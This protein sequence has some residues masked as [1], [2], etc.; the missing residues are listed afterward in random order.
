[1][2]DAQDSPE[3]RLVRDSFS[4]VPEDRDGIAYYVYYNDEKYYIILSA[5]ERLQIQFITKSNCILIEASN[6]E[7]T[8]GRRNAPTAIAPVVEAPQL[9]PQPAPVLEPIAPPV[10]LAPQPAPAPLP[11]PVAPQAPQEWQPQENTASLSAALQAIPP[12]LDDEEPAE[13]TAQL[14]TPL[15]PAV[16]ATFQ[17][18]KEPLPAE[19]EQL[20]TT[21]ARQPQPIAPQLIVDEEEEED[22]TPLFMPSKPTFDK[23]EEE[24]EDEAP[25]FIPQPQPKPAPKLSVAE[26]TVAPRGMERLQERVQQKTA[27]AEPKEEPV[28]APAPK[29]PSKTVNWDDEFNKSQARTRQAEETA[30]ESRNKSLDVREDALGAREE[31]VSDREHAV[32]TAEDRMDAKRLEIEGRKSRL[33]EQEHRLE[34]MQADLEYRREYLQQQRE[35]IAFLRSHIHNVLK[36]DFFPA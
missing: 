7:K 18:I 3:L 6:F 14:L 19:D 13:D 24:D 5:C 27:K 1:M 25:L 36:A 29:Q 16:L 34:K 21:R 22:D 2:S 4:P 17:A 26:A 12:L 15:P 28:V 32:A 33:E 30:E 10:Q 9:A 8:I 35:N 23:M 20:F 11:E 31:A